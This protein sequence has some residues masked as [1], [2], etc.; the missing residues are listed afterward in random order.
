MRI[1]LLSL[2][3]FASV[4]QAHEIGIEMSKDAESFL[5]KLT[6]AQ[7]AKAN[8][9]FKSDERFNW[10]FVPADRKGLPLKEMNKDQ[11]QAALKI[12]HSALS[13]SGET[14]ANSIRQLESVLKEIEKGKG[15]TRDPE[16]YYLT[17]F[18]TPSAQ[19]SWAWR[20]EGHHLEVQVTLLNGEII[21]LTP[22]FMGTN[23]GRVMEIGSSQKHVGLD[24]LGKEDKLG[25]DLANS[26]HDSQ[27]A[28]GIFGG[29]A[30]SDILSGQSREAK[31][32]QPL[33]ITLAD[34][35]AEQQAVF[36]QIVEEFVLRFKSELSAPTLKALREVP[37][38][39]L[40]FAWMGGLKEGEGHYYR[41]QGPDF[42]IELD[43]TQNNAN[44]VHT[45]WR[46]LKNDFGNDALRR[47]LATEHSTR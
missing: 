30:P 37:K 47:H 12:L 41:I 36:W 17:I 5:A 14:K 32:L 3:L 40:T 33:G 10:K 13:A 22:H 11:T 2:W 34:L 38:N 21:G 44:H 20:F 18:G 6:P 16:L 25:R 26:L 29:K 42:L 39:K 23:P 45:V 7:R 35:S 9:P 24:A 4:I 1:S 19:G 8:I 43:N 15:P 31:A 27:I 28:L 46:D